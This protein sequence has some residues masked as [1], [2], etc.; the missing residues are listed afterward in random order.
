MTGSDNCGDSRTVDCGSCPFG[1]CGLEG[2]PNRCGFVDARDGNKYG[3]VTIGSQIWMSHN[4]NYA[5][6]FS[7]CAL[8]VDPD[9]DPCDDP[10]HGRYYTWDVATQETSSDA[11]PSG[12]RGVCPEGWHLPSRAEWDQFADFVA[13]AHGVEGDE[14]GWPIARRLQD[15]FEWEPHDAQLGG[16]PTDDHGFSLLPAGVR[17]A[18]S[19]VNHKGTDSFTWSA[20]EDGEDVDR[21][22]WYT[23]GNVWDGLQ[24]IP[25]S[26]LFAASV[27]CV[28]D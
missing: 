3:F 4:L 20:T 24:G 26:K 9:P 11:V 2:T 16:V 23:S 1:E 14:I 6:T 15:Q 19:S 13:Q 28:K 25:N 22:V 27:R 7:Y 17:D 10:K 8:G 12:V 5:A 21:A 18:F